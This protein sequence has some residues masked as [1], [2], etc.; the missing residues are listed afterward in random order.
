MGTASNDGFY[1]Y[2]EKSG[3]QG[4]ESPQPLAD[5]TPWPIA[6]L[7]NWVARVSEPLFEQELDVVRRCLRRGSAMGDASCV[8][9]TARRLG[10]KSTTRPRS[11]PRVRPVQI[12]Q[13]NES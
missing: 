7:P 5:G 8:K 13:N 2:P 10:L 4:S 11:S 6:R 3:C 9:T 12:T 1:F